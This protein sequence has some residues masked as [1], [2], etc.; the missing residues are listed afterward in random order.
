MFNDNL[1]RIW[2]KFSNERTKGLKDRF[3]GWWR[4]V[5]VET[6]DPLQWYRVRVKIP[7]L[8]DH[9]LKP[10]ECPWADRAPWLGGKNAGAWMHPC[11]GDI[12]WVSF[13]KNHPY[14]II[15]TGFAMGT[16][17][18]RYPLESI[19]T[20]SPQA[21]KEDETPDEKPQDYLLN[22]LPKDRRPMS[23]GQ[24]DRYGSADILS[25]VGFFPDEHKKQPA[26]T[27]QDA[28][29]KKQ[30]EEGEP[31]RVN[32]PDKKY[33][34]RITKYGTFVVQ[35]DIGYYWKKPN[36]DQEDDGF[37]EFTGKFDEDRDFEVERYKF[38]TR[39]FNEDQPNSI[40]RDQRR[41]EVRTRAGHK[42]EMRD[43]GWA[44]AGGGRSVCEDVG[45]TKSRDD[46]GGKRTLSRWKDSD[47]RWV[48]LRTKGGHI[49]QAMDMGFHPEEDLFYSNSLM[50]EIGAQHDEE[51]T[52]EW[53]KRDARQIRIVT[54][55]G[56]KFVLDD[57]GTDGLAAE[58][59]EVPRGNG[60]L[61]KTRRSWET[62]PSTA[63]GFG[64]EAVDK[65][66]L[67]TSRWYSPKS[68]VI[69]MNDR[70]DY[71]M[72]CTDTKTEISRPWQ[73]LAE[74]E[75]ALKQ[76][77]T[78]KPEADTYHLK[79]DKLHGY[80]RLKTAS[81]GDNGR[82]PQPLGLLGADTGLN[83]GLEARDG[84]VGD[85]GPWAELVDIEH[86]GLWLSKKQKMG[87]WRSKE[88]KE[89]YIMIRDGDNSIVL[90]NAEDGP[91]QIFCKKDVEIIAEQ[92]IAMKA[93]RRISLKAGSSLELEA[94]GTGHAQLTS[95]EWKLDVPTTEGTSKPLD[96]QPLEQEK[97]EPEDRGLASGTTYEEVP[98][99]VIK[100]CE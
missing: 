46:Y 83:Q 52:H 5:V 33:T 57:R 93:G 1:A 64:F 76:S 41:F 3:T 59:N 95:G 58:F 2:N 54:R 75:F 56:T 13:E 98:E 40:K 34:A 92:N 26:P 43:V 63:R 15:W 87:I 25:S 66:E 38:I 71:V 50:N 19:F 55:W 85:E 61:L 27:G 80:V 73:K 86:R 94:G 6:N 68:K 18:K 9:D 65:D 21:V 28:I 74:N 44:Q 49:I 35:S 8:H 82:R 32:E 99:K 53:T 12:V 67:D 62:E 47:E 4:A 88:G 30:F 91:L 84:R 45:Q 81:G 14:G 29:S 10:Q 78:E 23:F 100:V 37:G 77:M 39:L 11:I 16:R 96:P 89:Q 24:R 48:K 97:K 31:P 17:R 36:K 79:L 22:Y 51:E 60:W 90:R 69:E 7:E 70:S 72:M 42:F 20:I